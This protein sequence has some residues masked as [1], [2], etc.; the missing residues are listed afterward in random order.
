MQIKKLNSK[1]INFAEKIAQN[2]KQ[3]IGFL[4]SALNN[5]VKNSISTIALF[6]KSNN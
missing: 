1:P 5:D 2:Y 6:Q 4:Y 3:K